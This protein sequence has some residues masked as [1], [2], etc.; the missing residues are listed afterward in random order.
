MKARAPATRSLRSV[1]GK[2]WISRS[3]SGLG[4]GDTTGLDQ[5]PG[6]ALPLVL[7]LL[8]DLGEEAEHDLARDLAGRQ[9]PLPEAVDP[10]DT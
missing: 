5:E 1:S 4:L 8:L 2:S 7:V 3:S 6:D 10:A 9:L